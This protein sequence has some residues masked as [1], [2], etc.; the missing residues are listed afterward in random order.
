MRIG[1]F[2][3]AALNDTVSHPVWNLSCFTSLH[4]SQSFPF[5]LLPPNTLA[6]LFWQLSC[7]GD[8]EVKCRKIEKRAITKLNPN[9]PQSPALPI[10]SREGEEINMLRGQEAGNTVYCNA[11]NLKN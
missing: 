11:V 7:F 10:A 3:C 4:T 9:T 8:T 1:L 2:I 5:P 6:L